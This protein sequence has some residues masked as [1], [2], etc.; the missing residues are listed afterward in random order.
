MK[1]TILFMVTN[2]T[3]LGHLTRGLAIARRLRE[4]EKQYE[5]I[6]LTT[7][8]ATEVLRE[9]NFM[10]YY[11][12]TKGLM[13][14]EI[15]W[16]VWNTFLSEQ[17]ESIIK[18]YE[19][20]AIVFD[21][22]V[23]Y[24][25]LLAN[26]NKK[27]AF[28]SVWIKREC[29]KKAFDKLEEKEKAFDLI[30][31]PN[32]V[33]DVIISNTK[34]KV[35]TNPIIFLEENEAYLR[36]SIRKQINLKDDESLFYIQL[37]AGNINNIERTL[38]TIVASIIKNPQ[39]H[40]LLGESIIGKHLD[41]KSNQITRIRN[42]PNAQYFRAIDGAI[43]AAG[44]N[45]VHELLLFGVPTL[46][47]PNKETAQDDQMA[48]VKKVEKENA[49]LI[50]EDLTFQ[51]IERGVNYLVNNKEQLSINAKALIKGNGALEA[52]KYIKALLD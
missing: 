15:T 33:N 52:A 41:I 1:K 26:L 18:L 47:V 3:G 40:I 38:E 43:S 30:I 28:K 42:F 12:P 51:E 22:A 2:G 46:F 23:P 16:K 17:I 37:G 36:E 35:Y 8:L 20:V 24:M 10:F 49:G 39:Y 25:G 6:F 11:V 19:P 50:L 29:Y 7:S 21:G 34:K 14:E 48:R 27:H 45:T 13:P 9:N 31:V 4:I 5:I 32:E 44:Y